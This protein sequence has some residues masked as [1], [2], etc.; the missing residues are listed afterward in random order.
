MGAMQLWVNH[1]E[2]HGMLRTMLEKHG[3]LERRVQLGLNGD[4]T[5]VTSP[6]TFVVV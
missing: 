3:L 6:P 5:H 1:Y 2:Q 4:A